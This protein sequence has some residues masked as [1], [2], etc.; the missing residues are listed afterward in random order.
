VVCPRFYSKIVRD[1]GIDDRQRDAVLPAEH[2]DRR[3][4]VEEVADHLPGHVLR[5]GRHA[6]PG[7]AVVAGKNQHLR[8][9]QGRRQRL[10]EQTD[11]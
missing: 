6:G 3:A 8:L 7:R 9:A 4:A 5:V 2:I 10:L 1:A 11:A